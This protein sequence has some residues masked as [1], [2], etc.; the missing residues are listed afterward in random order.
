M[1]P[2]LVIEQDELLPGLGLLGE[3][4]AALR[5]PLRRVRTWRDDLSG[6]HARDYG[7][8]VPLGGSMHAWEDDDFPFLREELAGLDEDALAEEIRHG[9]SNGDSLAFRA[10]LFDAFIGCASR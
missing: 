7:G 3:R 10:R 2:L 6:L 9:A 1:K 4:I 5:V 8:I